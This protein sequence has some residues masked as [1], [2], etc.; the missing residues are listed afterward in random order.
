LAP[1]HP[2]GPPGTVRLGLVGLGYWGPNLLRASVDLEDVEVTVLCDLD[3]ARLAR[4]ARRYPQVLATRRFEDIIEDDSIDAV[5][6]ATPIA[7]HRKLVKR[8]LEAGK[9]VLVEKPMASTTAEARELITIASERDLIL[10]PGHTFLYSAPVVRIKEMLDEGQLGEVYFITSTRVNLGIHR[11]D[12]SVIAD[13]GPHDFSILHYWIGPPTG[14]RAVARDSIVPGTW[15]VAF[16]D[17]LY[18]SGTLVRVEISWLAPTKLRRT[19]VAGRNAM[20]VYDDTSTEQ[21]RIF[22]CGV[23]F[24]EPQ[25]F[26]EHQLSYRVGDIVS[27]RL[28]TD[29][30]VRVELADFAESVRSGTQPRSNMMLGLDVVRMIEAAEASLWQNGAVVELDA[31]LDFLRGPRRTVNGRRPV[32]SGPLVLTP[33]NGNGANGGLFVLERKEQPLPASPS[34]VERVRAS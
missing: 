29:E 34:G 20:V 32:S 4:Q 31:P 28:A 6:V 18:P 5:I 23:E 26:G 14:V 17:L 1:P 27:P 22:D 33:K 13:L 10:M 21:V 8:S 12:G 16:V 15:D 2:A 11:S 24:V 30:P 25:N 19:V 9:H 3:P 7:S